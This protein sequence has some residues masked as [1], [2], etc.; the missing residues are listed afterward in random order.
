MYFAVLFIN[1]FYTDILVLSSSLIVDVLH[2]YN[3]AGNAKVFYMFLSSA[4][5]KLRRFKSFV[6]NCCYLEI[7]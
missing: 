7:L 5:L 3:D 2:P 1:L 6:N 4:F